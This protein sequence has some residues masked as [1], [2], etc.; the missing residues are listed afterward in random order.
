MRAEETEEKKNRR[1]RGETK[2]ILVFPSLR[3]KSFCS[4]WSHEN[5]LFSQ[6][7]KK[8]SHQ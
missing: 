1:K 2:Q 6:E 5:K 7:K 8:I 4:P 3:D